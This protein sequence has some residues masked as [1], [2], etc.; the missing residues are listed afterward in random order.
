LT[1]AETEGLA[2]LEEGEQ[3]LRDAALTMVRA[4]GGAIYAV[5][6]VAV[7]ALR[8]SLGQSAAFRLLRERRL[9]PSAAVLLRTQ[10]DSAL[11]F[12]SLW[13][14]SDPEALTHEIIRGEAVHGLLDRSGQKLTDRRLAELQS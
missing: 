12:S 1:E 14:V 3:R 9:F 5:D 11:L 13:Y 4:R 10:L 2:L 8:R 6:L 7:A